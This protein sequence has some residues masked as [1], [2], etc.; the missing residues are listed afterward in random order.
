MLSTTKILSND[1][2]GFFMRKLAFGF[3]ILL[4]LAAVVLLYLGRAAIFPAQ[5]PKSQLFI[6]GTVLTMDAE[7]RIVEA[8][9]LEGKRIAAL[10][11]SREILTLKRESS[12]VHD[13]KGATLLP[14]F[15]DAHGH[16][17][18]WGGDG[19]VV[20][21]NSPPIGK[22]SNMEQLLTKLKRVSKTKPAGEWLVGVGYDDSLLAEKR[23]PN[24]WDLDK[25]SDEHPIYLL[26]ISGHIGAANSAALKLAGISENSEAPSGG[27]IQRSEDG[28][29]NGVLEETA[30]LG[31]TEL[32]LDFS[33]FDFFNMAKAAS[34]DYARVGVT[35]AQSGLVPEKFIQG[36]SLV[37]KLGMVSQRLELWPDQ[38][39]GL[40]W[41]DKTFDPEEYETDKLNIGAIKLVSDGS[42][43]GFT[44]YLLQPYHTPYKGDPDYRGYPTIDQPKLNNIVSKIHQAGMQLAIHANGDAAIQSVIDAVAQAQ[45]Q[46]PREDTRHI[47][48]H[49][50]MAT[51]E[52]LAQMK[53]LGLTPSFFSAHTYYWGDR[54]HD[55]FMGPER[56]ARMSPAR[57]ALDIELPFTV[58]LDSPVVPMDPLLLV[59]STVNRQSSSGKIIGEQQRISAEQA[60][61]A[62]T[63]DAAWQIFQEDSRGSLEEG[64]YADLVVLDGNPLENPQEIRNLQVLKTVVGGITIY[65]Q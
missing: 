2:T 20:D 13:L 3:F 4:I 30:R 47:V 57:S 59:W 14:G 25:V 36:L 11:S 41:L 24:R 26:H 60:L 21:L 15:I 56:A 6:N 39:T 37:S 61:R 16:F 5:P 44:G 53:Q 18:G 58:H 28:Q 10:G 17:P 65:E 34:K 27:V 51:D 22:I 52:Q 12:I 1:D 48:I 49:A 50:Q 55:I 19:L 43:Q 7:H 8:I 62:I 63:I 46:Y 23:H 38:E 42:I 33:V 9:A 45:K 54:H 64:K 35:T 29:I 31:I 40:H 32:A